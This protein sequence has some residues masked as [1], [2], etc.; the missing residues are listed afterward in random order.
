MPSTTIHPV[1]H[2]PPPVL[3]R[4]ARD[5]SCRAGSV[6]VSELSQPTLASAVRERT[7]AA[8]TPS[9][10]VTTIGRSETRG[11]RYVGASAQP[12]GYAT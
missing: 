9:L 10:F 11:A 2:V 4:D 1:K 7:N 8:T 12:V 5:A 3:S 6:P